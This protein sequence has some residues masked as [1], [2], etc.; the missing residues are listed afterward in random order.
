L[1]AQLLVIVCLSFGR[2]YIAERFQQTMVVEP[3]YPFQRG[4]LDGLTRFPRSVEVDQ[5]SLV[6]PVDGFS[7]G[8]IVAVAFAT[9]RRLDAGLCQAFA[10]LY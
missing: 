7:Q 3:R 10:V 6:E 4:Q 5:F 8:I 2:R 9:H 1:T